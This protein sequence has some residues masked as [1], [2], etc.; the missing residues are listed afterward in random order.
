MVQ[1][2]FLPCNNIMMKGVIY[3]CF[4]FSKLIV[5]IYYIIAANYSV[6]VCWTSSK[7]R[8]DTLSIQYSQWRDSV[9]HD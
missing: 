7:A 5:F 8:E 2:F 4:H 9:C 6:D 3:S 1:L